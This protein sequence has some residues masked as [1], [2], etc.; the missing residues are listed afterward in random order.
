MYINL[1][2]RKHSSASTAKHVYILSEKSA[3]EMTISRSTVLLQIVGLIVTYLV[4]AL[5]FGQ[6]GQ[7]CEAV[8]EAKNCTGTT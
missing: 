6:S 3:C 4:I 5:Q 2:Q 8:V 1:V 7:P